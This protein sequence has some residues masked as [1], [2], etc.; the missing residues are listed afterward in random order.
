MYVEWKQGDEQDGARKMNKQQSTT[1]TANQQRIRNKA[2]DAIQPMSGT[3]T[4]MIL[5]FFRTSLLKK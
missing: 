2:D 1:T 4:I 3:T 5:V